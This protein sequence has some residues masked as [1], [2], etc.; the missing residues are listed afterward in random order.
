MSKLFSSITDWFDH[1]I[2]R[3][4]RWR[5]GGNR[6]RRDRNSLNRDRKL[7]FSEIHN[8][9]T[10]H[11]HHHN[12]HHH[13]QQQQQQ[14][15]RHKPTESGG[16]S[17]PIMIGYYPD[18]VIQ[19]GNGGGGGV[20]VDV[21]SKSKN[22]ER[23]FIRRLL[24]CSPCC[25]V[26][27]ICSNRKRSFNPGTYSKESNRSDA[28]IISNRI[29]RQQ[30]S[31]NSSS[32]AC[33]TAS[34]VQLSANLLNDQSTNSTPP[35]I[36]LDS[37]FNVP[38]SNSNI[39]NNHDDGDDDDDDDDGFNP[40]EEQNQNNSLNKCIPTNHQQSKPNYHRHQSMPSPNSPNKSNNNNNNNNSFL[41]KLSKK[42]KI[43]S[44]IGESYSNQINSARIEVSTK[45]LMK[46]LAELMRRQQTNVNNDP[47]SLSSTSKCQYSKF[48]TTKSQFTVELVNELL[49]EWYIKIYEF[50]KDS[51][52]KIHFTITKLNIEFLEN[53][54]YLFVHVL[55][56]KFP[57][58]FMIVIEVAV[59]SLV[60]EI[61]SCQN[62]ILQ[63]M[64]QYQSN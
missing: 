55:N 48:A 29:Y 3:I 5:P 20:G 7:S 38:S 40:N 30:I 34:I 1:Q 23:S 56:T 18:E 54:I 15:K 4:S 49:Y 36:V 53:K 37:V 19:I 44:I 41:Q 13:Q 64:F 24:Q 39:V 47:F 35:I 21:R 2:F 42:S 10:Q 43:S 51:Q 60:V 8:S 31:L 14:R 6:R 9:T 33:E 57:I 50:D 58:I 16:E 62:L 59:L 61:S 26:D 11:H 32:S 52:F 12:H 17:P 22:G 27:Q 25:G 63:I 28:A 45:R 46:E